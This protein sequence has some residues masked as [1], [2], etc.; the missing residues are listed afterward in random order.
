MHFRRKLNEFIEGKIF[1]CQAYSLVSVFTIIHG[2][3]YFE[4]MIVET[5]KTIATPVRSLSDVKKKS[6]DIKTNI[7]AQKANACFLTFA[8][9]NVVTAVTIHRQDIQSQ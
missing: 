1:S 3:T 2:A 5:L 4:I 6:Y 8:V 9:W 7:K